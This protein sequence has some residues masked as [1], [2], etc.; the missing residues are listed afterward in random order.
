TLSPEQA[1]VVELPKDYH[2]SQNYPNPFNP[3]TRI[4]YSLPV[5]AHVTLKVYDILGRELATLVNE[6]QESGYK[7]VLFNSENLSSGLYIYKLTAGASTGL[8]FTDIK[9]MILIK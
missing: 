2:L 1:I 4:E 3:V 5:D 9:K 6:M 7:S 8:A